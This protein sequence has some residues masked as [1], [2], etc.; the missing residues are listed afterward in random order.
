MALFLPLSFFFF[1]LGRVVNKTRGDVVLRIIGAGERSVWLTRL[2]VVT[3]LGRIPEL[4]VTEEGPISPRYMNQFSVHP[5]LG[6][7]HLLARRCTRRNQQ[8][9]LPVV[10]VGVDWNE[11]GIKMGPSLCKTMDVSRSSGCRSSCFDAS[12]F[13]CPFLK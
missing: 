9:S 12:S 4:G 7:G 5:H 11:R 2:G 10:G 3:W 6:K 8:V 13:Q 1:L